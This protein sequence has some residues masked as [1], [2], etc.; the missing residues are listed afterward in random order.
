MEGEENMDSIEFDHNKYDLK[1]LLDAKYSFLEKLRDRAPGTYKHCQNVSS[2]C[3]AVALELDIDPNLMRVLGMYHDAGKLTLPECFYEN[4]NGSGN[5]H[6]E[7]DPMISFHLLSKHVADG[8][9]I[10]IQLEEFPSELI[11]PITQHHGNSILKSLAIKSGVEEDMFRYKNTTPPTTLEAAILMICDSVE[12][13]VRSKEH[14]NED[15][16]VDDIR[17]IIRNTIERLEGDDQLDEI[18]VGDLKKIKKA[19]QRDLESKYH[20]RDAKAYE[21]D[22]EKTIKEKKK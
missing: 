11:I 17:G 22:D 14:N 2:L 15:V 1:Q 6:D 3:E 21:E 13:T 8:A 5:M 9:L 7:L 4:Q 19:L 18:K 12:A 20:K 10:L 16:D